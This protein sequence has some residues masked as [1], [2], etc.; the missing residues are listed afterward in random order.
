MSQTLLRSLLFHFSLVL[1]PGDQSKPSVAPQHSFL[2]V[3]Y[4]LLL[5]S[6]KNQNTSFEG[7]DLAAGASV[8]GNDF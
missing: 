6:V 5:F 7:L 2:R 1:P 4:P 3:N 8:S